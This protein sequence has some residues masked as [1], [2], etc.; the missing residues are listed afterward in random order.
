MSYQEKI[1]TIE[2][3]I[4]NK[5]F[6]SAEQDLLQII[7][8][9]KIKNIE[10]DKYIYYSFYNYIETLIYWKKYN[11]SKKILQLENNIADV[12]YLLGFINFETKNYGN[13]IQY[14][15]KAIEWNPVNS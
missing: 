11:P 14:L 15:D 4:R 9:E 2:T 3:K 10:D 12:Y 5:E 13:A 7:N 8:D 6:Y 1:A